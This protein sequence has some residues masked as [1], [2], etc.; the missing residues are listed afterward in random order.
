M[1][2][3]LRAAHIVKKMTKKKYLF[4]HSTVAC[5]G[6]FATFLV[7]SYVIWR[8]SGKVG[9]S[10]KNDSLT[11]EKLKKNKPVLTLVCELFNKKKPILLPPCGSTFFPPTFYYVLLKMYLEI[12][13]NLI[14]T[15]T[16][17]QKNKNHSRNN[18]VPIPH[19]M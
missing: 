6:V 11:V 12:T 1:L 7:E 14:P 8:L 13:F 19:Q 15:N 17:Y 18:M 2:L 9:I 5:T 16:F 3:Y 4:T 10:S